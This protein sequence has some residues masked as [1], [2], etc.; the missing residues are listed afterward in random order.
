MNQDQTT[1]VVVAAHMLVR[2]GVRALLARETDLLVI[3]EASDARAAVDLK[4]DPRVVIL[5]VGVP[6][7][8]CINATRQLLE[9]FAHSRVVCLSSC[10]DQ[11]QVDGLV[12]AGVKGCLVRE[13]GATDLVNAVR[14]VARDERYLPGALPHHQGGLSPREEEVLRLLAEG[15]T[16]KEIASRLDVAVST[17]ETYRKQVMSKLDLHSVAA[18]TRFAVRMGLAPLE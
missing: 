16:S 3:G 18:L 13:S 17:I 4:I 10:V 5:D 2:D 9:H 6:G 15:L 14:A 1:V 12:Q 7:S 8:R 11:R